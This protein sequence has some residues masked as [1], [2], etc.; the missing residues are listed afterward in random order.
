MKGRALKWQKTD[1]GV[2]LE[3]P[4]G[5]RL[6]VMDR[7]MDDEAK[8]TK[9]VSLHVPPIIIECEW[10]SAREAKRVASEVLF[11]VLELIKSDFEGA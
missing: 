2:M 7:Q 6:Y 3:T 4:H 1:S 10:K 5:I 9:T 8:R 11:E